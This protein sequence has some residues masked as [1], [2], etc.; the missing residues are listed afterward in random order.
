MAKLKASTMTLCAGLNTSVNIELAYD[1]LSVIYPTNEDGSRFVHPKNTRDKI[2]YFGIPN[3]IVCIKYKGKIRG[4]RQNEGQMNNVVSI[5]LQNNEKNINLKLAKTNLQLTGAKSE[6]KGRD[7]FLVLCA[8]V[9]M[10]QSHLNYIRNLPEQVQVQT[11]QWVL[12]RNREYFNS[13][14][15]LSS[16]KFEDIQRESYNS[17]IDTRMA[18]YYWQFVDD[19]DDFETYENKVKFIDQIIKNPEMNLV[20]EEVTITDYRI[21]NSVYNYNLG[22]EVS[23]IELSTS[24]LK[25]GFSVDFHNWNSAQMKV[26]IPIEDDTFTISGESTSISSGSVKTNSSK[27]KI[28]AHRFS[29]TQ[30]GSIKQTSPASFED[31]QEAYELFTSG[32]QTYMSELR[33]F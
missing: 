22:I 27:Q 32:I 19:Y 4:I 13:E 3:S 29:M 31:A 7:A 14:G 20:T 12:D 6:E 21:S 5:D 28:K 18:M 11:I 25:Q 23:L 24:M 9:N 16:F 30:Q 15:M 1:L 33:K 17:A 2:P 26:A 8:H 10:T